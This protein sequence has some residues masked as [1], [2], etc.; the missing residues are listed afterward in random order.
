VTADD[1]KSS[2]FFG[3]T[4]VL[5]WKMDP[6]RGQDNNLNLQKDFLAFLFPESSS[7]HQR[8]HDSQQNEVMNA[9]TAHGQRSNSGMLNFTGTSN[10]PPFNQQLDLM[11]MSN[12]MSMQGMDSTAVP[13]LPSSTGLT[14][15]VIFEQQYKLTQLHQLQQ[16]QNQIQN[17]IFQ[18]Q[19]SRHN[20]VIQ[21]S[22]LS[23][24][25]ISLP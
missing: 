9:A 3:I 18:Q 19:V 25:S 15:Q 4:P 5:G 6:S 2:L 13:A 8:D 10:P 24:I 16:L 11:T 12:L 7:D 17:Q 14:P 22:C 20:S 21:T 23:I 1:P